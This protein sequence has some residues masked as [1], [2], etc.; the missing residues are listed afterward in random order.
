VVSHQI[1]SQILQITLH[2][3]MLIH[4]P[5][6]NSFLRF[7]VIAKNRCIP[8]IVVLSKNRCI[9][10]KSLY[11][12]KS[13]FLSNQKPPH[14]FPYRLSKWIRLTSF[15]ENGITLVIKEISSARIKFLQ[16]WLKDR[17]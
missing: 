2:A 3:F 5:L 1:I 11:C 15:N 9:V 13:S 10:K 4:I 16:Y 6:S 12:Q 7:F 8:K 17:T 14:N